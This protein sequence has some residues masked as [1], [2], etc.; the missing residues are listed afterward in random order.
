[1][2]RM[3]IT[4]EGT[5]NDRHSGEQLG[6]VFRQEDQSA[7]TDREHQVGRTLPIFP[8]KKISLPL[9]LLLARK[10]GHIE[11]LT[12]KLDTLFGGSREGRADGLI[13]DNIGRQ[14]PLIRIEH[15]YALDRNLPGRAGAGQVENQ[16][17]GGAETEKSHNPHRRLRQIFSN[18]F[19]RKRHGFSGLGS[20]APKVLSKH[21]KP[22]NSAFPRVHFYRFIANSLRSAAWKKLSAS[23]PLLEKEIRGGAAGVRACLKC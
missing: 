23:K 4:G 3:R 18:Y 12:V 21:A 11:E 2:I 15:E 17:H 20:S 10:T 16:E 1:M 9:L 14:Q 13:H 7:S 19:G 8:P 22:S 5:I 6:P